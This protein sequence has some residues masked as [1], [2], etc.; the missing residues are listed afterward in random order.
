[1]DVKIE[2]KEQLKVIG[3]QQFLFYLYNLL[4]TIAQEFIGIVT[5]SFMLELYFT[6]KTLI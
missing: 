4:S 5:W 2:T 6:V 3:T 1:M